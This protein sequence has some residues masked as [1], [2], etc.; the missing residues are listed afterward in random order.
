V[1]H[2]VDRPDDILRLLSLSS[3]ER[4]G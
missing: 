2:R 4:P 1:E 3:Q